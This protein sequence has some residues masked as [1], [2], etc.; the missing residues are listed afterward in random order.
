MGTLSL[1]NSTEK[2]VHSRIREEFAIQPLMAEEV[3]SENDLA[4]LP[5][6]IKKYIA[7][8]GAVGK[9]KPQNVCIEFD[10]DMFRKQGD[11]PMKAG[12]KQYNFYGSYTRIFLMKASKMFIPFLATHI[13]S[14][15]QATFVVRVANMFNMVDMK[16]EVLTKAET[17]T[18]L[19]DMCVFVPGNLID[20][21][22][23][24]K[25][26][27][28][29]SCE[30][31][32]INGKYKVSAVLYFNEKGE[33]INFVSDDRLALQNDGTI[34]QARWSTPVGDYKVLDGRRIPTYGETIWNYPEGDFTYG[35]FRLKKIQYNVSQ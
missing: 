22:L 14:H 5:L 16:G 30:V 28:A 18:V 11:T 9:S 6:P 12:S 13:Y 3:L 32:L 21:R 10:A 4:H 19:N 20:K 27:D 34:K 24:W 25:E 2:L 33:L 15:Q 1:F 29:L 7:Y 17:V 35:K 31:T 23:S 8:A 26:I